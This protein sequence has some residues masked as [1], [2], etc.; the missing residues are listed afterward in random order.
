MIPKVPW[1]NQGSRSYLAI[2]HQFIGVIIL[3]SR[4]LYQQMPVQTAQVVEKMSASPTILEFFHDQ[5]SFFCERLALGA[6]VELEKHTETALWLLFSPTRPA[7]RSS[8]CDTALTDLISTEK[9]PSWLPKKLLIMKLHRLM[10][11]VLSG[12][13]S[14]FSLP[15]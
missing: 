5:G 6:P 14:P 3:I 13:A 10:L 2:L 11:L 9:S 12:G 15:R 7:S 8:D 1:L 4:P